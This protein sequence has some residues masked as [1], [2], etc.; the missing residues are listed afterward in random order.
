MRI[1]AN[2]SL[3]QPGNQAI[4]V[5]P[6]SRFK[7]VADLAAAKATIGLNTQNNIGQVLLRRALP[8]GRADS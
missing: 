7:T 1:I 8:A 4:Y 6:R 3:M 2:A 5:L